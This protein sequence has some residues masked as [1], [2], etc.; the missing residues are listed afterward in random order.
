M[1]GIY[2]RLSK[3]ANGLYAGAVA[4]FE[5]GDFWWAE[6]TAG[7][8]MGVATFL[9]SDEDTPDEMRPHAELIVSQSTAL[10]EQARS[11]WLKQQTESRL[12]GPS[13]Q[14]REIGEIGLY[15][16]DIIRTAVT[17]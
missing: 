6:L 16:E 9:F 4:A 10:A 5:V 15:I 11:A 12:S 8:A 1:S 13:H 17:E 7:A 2:E 14:S 3:S